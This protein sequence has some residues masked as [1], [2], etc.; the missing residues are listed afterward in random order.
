[1]FSLP[2]P[3]LLFTHL[4]SYLFICSNISAL[5][6][7]T[8]DACSL[9]ISA[10]V[11]CLFLF[12]PSPSFSPQCHRMWKD[13]NVYEANSLLCYISVHWVRPL[14]SLN[15]KSP[16]QRANCQ[17]APL[18]DTSWINVDLVF[19]HT[20]EQYKRAIYFPLWF[21]SHAHFSLSL[22]ISLSS[23]PPLTLSLSLSLSHSLLDSICKYYPWR[24][25]ALLFKIFK[26]SNCIPKCIWKRCCECRLAVLTV[27]LGGYH[28][29]VLMKHL[30]V[31]FMS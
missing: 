31:C 8:C 12:F 7:I 5:H 17:C 16:I 11:C 6:F 22:S 26:N 20:L 19:L 9:K 3:P 2:P 25:L 10:S 29:A 13:V 28:R 30:S 23:S 21:V 15:D 18:I 14:V 1:M 4:F 27:F 24:E